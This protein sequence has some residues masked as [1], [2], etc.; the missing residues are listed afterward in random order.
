MTKSVKVLS[1]AVALFCFSVVSS[2]QSLQEVTEAYNKG[3]EMM[4]AGD[5]DGAITE[6]EKCVEMAKQVGEDAED[7]QFVAESAIPNLYLQKANR[8]NQ[9][10]DFPA[11][12]VALK[13][14]VDAAERYNNADV[15]ERAERTIP[16]VYLA[17]GS[18]DFQAQKFEEAI[19]NL[20][21]VIARDPSVARAFFIIGASYQSLRNEPKMEEYYKLAIEKG[22]AGGDA[23]SVQQAKTQLSRFYLNAGITAQRAQRWDEAI[24][25]FT[26]TVEVD[27]QH[28]D[29]FYSLSSCYNSKRSWD[30]AIAAGEKALALRQ[31]SGGALDGVYYQ[32]GT[33]Y[34]GKNNNARAC[35]Y[36]KLVG[37][38]TFLAAAK[39]Q[40]E[41]ALKCN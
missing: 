32:L 14:T 3:A 11:T 20:E 34:A 41:T 21:Q 16:Q 26:K 23:T 38:G 28:A 24:A 29:A 15:K 36:F 39:Y 5:L 4:A 6:L 30:D 37:E 33:A 18:A 10:R 2:A 22:T 25:A 13:A 35:E 9:T 8:I 27:D 7:L 12:L 19:Q 31:G 40:I 17:M 1:I